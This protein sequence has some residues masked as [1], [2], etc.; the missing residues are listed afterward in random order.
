MAGPDRRVVEGVVKYPPVLGFTRTP[1]GMAAR[2]ANTVH[3]PDGMT[4]VVFV[5][6]RAEIAEQRLA[7]GRQVRAAGRWDSE[8]ERFEVDRFDVDGDAEPHPYQLTGH[9]RE[10]PAVALDSRQLDAGVDEAGVDIGAAPA[11]RP[12]AE[13]AGGGG[14]VRFKVNQRVVALDRGNVGSVVGVYE[15][16][17]EVAVRFRARDGREATRTFL[18][19][20]LEPAPRRRSPDRRQRQD[21]ATGERPEPQP[22]GSRAGRPSRGRSDRQRRQGSST[23]AD[24]PSAAGSGG[25]REPGGGASRPRPLRVH[26]RPIDPETGAM[27]L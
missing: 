14:G 17:G 27:L 20:Q 4:T 15:D 16:R 26:T 24:R 23:Q 12:S 10:A 19:S 13:G 3:G 22:G 25:G 1:D 2:L 6:G 9:A 11:S 7:A 8:H 5:G 18:A 21:P